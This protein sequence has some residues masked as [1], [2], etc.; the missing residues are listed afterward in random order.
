[1]TALSTSDEKTV[2][3]LLMVVMEKL[4]KQDFDLPP[5]PQIANQVLALATD[6]K[7]DASKLTAVIGQDP[8]LTAKLFQTSNSVV[9]GTTRQIES[10]QQAISWLGLNTVA[11][12]AFTLSIQSGTF[13]VHGYDREVK[14]LW[15]HM[16][17]TAFYAKS[18]AELIG[19]KSETAFLSGLLCAIGKPLIIHIVNQYQQDPASRIPW[20][21]IVTLMQE[22]YV[23]VGRQLAEAWGLP[24][25][26]K[27]VINLH[28][29]H[30]YHLATSP[31]KSAPIICLANHFA[32]HALDPTSFSENAIRTHPV[33][34]A[35][36]VPDDVIDA[37]LESAPSMQARADGMLT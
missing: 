13:K 5:L 9:Q 12:T 8:I 28:Q 34:Q 37:L 10:L 33:I 26:V 11:G 1:M 7:A 21:T 22:S 2:E 19:C 29:D 14:G 4:A 18:I 32:T 23:E 36:Q 35:L 6:P 17:T 3:V 25:S 15:R 24:D 27:E 31:S 30:S 16:V 20:T